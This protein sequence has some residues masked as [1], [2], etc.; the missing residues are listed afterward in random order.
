MAARRQGTTLRLRVCGRRG[1]PHHSCKIPA[2]NGAPGG[3]P[4]KSTVSGHAA[5]AG[6]HQ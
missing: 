2:R 3:C 4:A 6:N 1:S 5:R